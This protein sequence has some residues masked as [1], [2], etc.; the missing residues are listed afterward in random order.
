MY[1]YPNIPTI[2]YYSKKHQSPELLKKQT[3]KNQNIGKNG[4]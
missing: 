4:T 1:N 3:P 2:P